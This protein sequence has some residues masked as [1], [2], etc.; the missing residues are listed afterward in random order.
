MKI[1]DHFFMMHVYFRRFFIFFSLLLTGWLDLV[2]GF[3]YS[4]TV[5]YLVPVSVAAWY[6]TPRIALATIILAGLTW[7]YSDFKTGHIYSSP[8]I[9]WW[10]AGVR[11]ISFAVVAFLLIRVKTVLEEM[12]RMAMKDSLTGLNNSRAFQL[13]YQTLQRNRKA[14]QSAICIIDL[15]GF[16]QVNDRLG[17]SRGDDVLIHFAQILQQSVSRSDIVARMGG[18]EFVVLLSDTSA[19]AIAQYEQTLR[20]LFAQTDMKQNYGVD[21]SMG[22]SLFCELPTSLDAAKHHADRLMYQSKDQGKSKTTV[23]MV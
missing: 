14:Q 9:P 15:D 17:H 1:L 7:L 19:V 3:E 8:I 13:Q 2:T 4:I 6:E 21:F 18:D 12:T 10:N 5:F 23:G 11:L 22:V 16:K 20:Q